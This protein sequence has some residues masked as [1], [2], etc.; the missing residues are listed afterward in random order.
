[1]NRFCRSMFVLSLIGA[2]GMTILLCY[3]SNASAA[4]KYDCVLRN[5]SHTTPPFKVEKAVSCDFFETKTKMRDLYAMFP[6]CPY[7]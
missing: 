5:D 7:L 6:V 4:E 3:V 1:M 2:A